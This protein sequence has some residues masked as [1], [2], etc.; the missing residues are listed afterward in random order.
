[1]AQIDGAIARGMERGIEQAPNGGNVHKLGLALGLIGLHEA[2]N[3]GPRQDQTLAELDGKARDVIALRITAVRDKLGQLLVLPEVRTW[4]GAVREGALREVLGSDF[5]GEIRKFA[6][7]LSGFAF[8]RTIGGLAPTERTQRLQAE[9]AKLTVLD[10][11]LVP[12]VAVIWSAREVLTNPLPILQTATEEELEAGIELFL[13]AL[14]DSGALESG[15]DGAK[16]GAWTIGVLK[17]AAEGAGALNVAN[18]IAKALAKVPHRAFLA[19]IVSGK[20]E[21]MLDKADLPAEYKDVARH[22]FSVATRRAWVGSGVTTLT[23]L[24]ALAVVFA[25]WPPKDHRGNVLWSEVGLMSAN[26]L[27]GLG[28]VP[29]MAQFGKEVFAPIIKKIRIDPSAQLTRRIAGLARGVGGILTR[30]GPLGDLLFAV[31]NVATA[32]K[33]HRN[34]DSFGLAAQVQQ[35]VG[36]TVT[37][38]CAAVIIYASAPVVVV[39]AAAVGLVAAFYTL[40][41]SFLD[42]KFGES[43]LVGLARRNLRDLGI[44]DAEEGTTFGVTK[45]EANSVAANGDIEVEFRDASLHYARA[46][47]RKLGPTDRARVINQLADRRPTDDE[48]MLICMIL[49]DTPV[50]GGQLLSLLGATDPRRIAA[51]LRRDSQAAAVLV[52]TAHAYTAANESPGPALTDQLAEHMAQRREGVLEDF[53]TKLTATPVT[54]DQIDLATYQ[55][56]A[57]AA[58][59][60]ACKA[61]LTGRP[62]AAESNVFATFI[63]LTSWEQLRGLMECGGVPLVHMLEQKLRGDAW[64][65]IQ[66]RMLDPQAGEA[67]NRLATQRETLYGLTRT[68]LMAGY[69]KMSSSVIEDRATRADR[70]EKLVLLSNYL[71]NPMVSGENVVGIVLELGSVD[72]GEFLYI[73]ESSSAERIARALTDDAEAARAMVKTLTAYRS[74]GRPPGPALY[75]QLETHCR[76]QRAAVIDAFLDALGSPQL[77]ELDAGRLAAAA[78]MFDFDGTDRHEGL[79]MFKMLDR[80]SDEQFN[81]VVELGHV[82]YLRLLKKSVDDPI[83]ARI[84]AR[85]E[86]GAATPHVKNIALQVGP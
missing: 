72:D 77:A 29:T 33:E 68:P 55:R 85:L 30:I 84:Q 17:R 3:L 20:F 59:C 5:R 78:M 57:P 70:F 25:S 26:L 13:G 60:A 48:Q 11:D 12:E 71:D 28:A 65:K 75:G 40:G 45:F 27:A 52:H 74:A 53:V 50:E 61:F 46:E 9:L 41:V 80:T 19:A 73:V 16:K 79:V 64:S 34:E 39:A 18:Q 62:T 35:A 8:W 63:L 54:L 1:M 43:D 24:V 83:W 14:D 69:V 21:D 22:V 2:T 36:N 49:L 66:T 82:S 7:H 6:E 37:A 51:V 4:L 56:I 10:P 58:L 67:V 81:R 76:D 31:V 42:A 86:S 38:V 23:G 47:A 15:V 44:S 32:F